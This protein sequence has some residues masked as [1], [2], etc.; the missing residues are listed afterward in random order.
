MDLVRTMS[1]SFTDEWLKLADHHKSLPRMLCVITRSPRYDPLILPTQTNSAIVKSS[2]TRHPFLVVLAI[3]LPSCPALV[4]LLRSQDE[5]PVLDGSSA[6]RP[7]SSPSQ[8]RSSLGRIT[9]QAL[10]F[11]D[12][13]PS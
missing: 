4:L 9:L 6:L 1:M 11:C 13:Y 10:G 7:N 5:V 3:A 12:H 8:G 2:R